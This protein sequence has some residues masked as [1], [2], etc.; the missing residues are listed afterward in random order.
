VPATKTAG[1]TVAASRPT[2]PAISVAKFREALLQLDQV[3]DANAQTFIEHGQRY[4]EQ[5]REATARPLSAV[6]VAEIAAGFNV[7]LAEAKEQIDAAGLTTTDEP[8]PQ[9]ILLAAG[10]S[11]TPALFD[12]ALRL[13]ALLEM[14]NAEFAEA[15]AADELDERLDE[16]V[17]AY[18]QEDLVV[19]RE[20]VGRAWE[21]LSLAMGHTP[22][23][24]WGLIAKT[25][26]KAVSQGM[27]QLAATASSMQS[28]GSPPPTA[29]PDTTS[30]TAPPG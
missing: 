19:L 1:R 16:R 25:M 20:R 2:L 22:G 13:A 4:R 26:W 6:E 28:T 27:S 24:A 3:V 30:S 5:H 10:V 14:P 23:K 21:H 7:E 11:T 9:E 8:E 15:H 29:G 17:A 12:A 18:D